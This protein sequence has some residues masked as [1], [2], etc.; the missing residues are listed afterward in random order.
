MVTINSKHEAAMVMHDLVTS[1]EEQDKGF[2][3]DDS[4]FEYDCFT[5]EEAAEIDAKL[6]L[7]RKFLS[8]EELWEVVSD[9]LGWD[10]E[11]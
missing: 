1:L 7:I 10:D 5:K 3:Y 6:K 11:E 4:P 9:A 8:E 2:H